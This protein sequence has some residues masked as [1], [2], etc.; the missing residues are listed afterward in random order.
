MS[1]VGIVTDSTNCVPKEFIKEYKIQIAPVHLILD[2]K[3]Y[4]DQVDISP[5]EF[6]R[7][8]KVLKEMP[9]TSAASP[10][11]WTNAINEAAKSA[12]SIVCIA[13]SKY[14]SATYESAIQA[15]DILR[16]ENPNLNIEVLDSQTATG[17][18]GF[19]VLEA[20]RAAQAGKSLAEVVQV[21]FDM[22]S[23]VKFFISPDTLK[24]LMRIGR[25][26]K[27]A[28][29]GE[30]L[31]VKPIIGMVNRTGRME[32]L[33]KTMGKLKSMAKMVDMVKEYVET[34]KPIHVNVHYSDRIEDGEELK[35]IVTSRYDCTEV[36]LTEFTPVMA[37]ALGPV[38]GLAFYS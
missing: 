17:A 5:A 20:A 30:M 1:K 8:F 13:L 23:R 28:I 3:D 18:H 16:S 22:M 19:V 14:L 11:D 31:K 10:G 25:A 38:V 26:P 21:A 4:R 36:Y 2:G 35:K 29:I 15:T 34:E 9:T 33:G 12:D 27:T 32:N 6:W 7:Q 24:Y 37:A